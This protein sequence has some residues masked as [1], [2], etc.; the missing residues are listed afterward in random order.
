MGDLH[1][2]T[3]YIAGVTKQLAAAAGQTTLIAPADTAAL[4]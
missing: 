1:S 4:W 3:H 2:H